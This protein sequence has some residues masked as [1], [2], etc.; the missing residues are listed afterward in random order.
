MRL[1]ARSD[2]TRCAQGS[3]GN[4]SA[5]TV[6]LFDGVLREGERVRV[7][8]EPVDTWGRPFVAASLPADWLTFTLSPASVATLTHDGNCALLEPTTAWAAAAGESTALLGALMTTSQPAVAPTAWR[9]LTIE[10]LSNQTGATTS[11]SGDSRDGD[12]RDGDTQ[13]R[14][15]P[16]WLPIAVAIVVLMAVKALFGGSRGQEPTVGSLDPRA[17]YP[18]LRSKH[19]HGGPCSP[20]LQRQA[21]FT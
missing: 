14:G 20:K 12:T 19:A 16:T 8:A 21:A 15:S 18:E 17:S 9:P 10:R 3:G 4:C 2:G 13:A 11:G 6:Y 5:D 7:C 1:L